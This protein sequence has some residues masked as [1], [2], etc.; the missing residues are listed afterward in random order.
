MK[1]G[2]IDVQ[3]HWSE[4]YRFIDEDAKGVPRV[5][6]TVVLPGT[7]E[8]G[9]GKVLDVVWFVDSKTECDVQVYLRR[10]TCD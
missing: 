2:Y 9:T 3:D 8:Y 5:G 7:T 1:V 10:K 6:D 4:P